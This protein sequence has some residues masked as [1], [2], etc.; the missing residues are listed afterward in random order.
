MSTR[1]DFLDRPPAP[2]RLFFELGIMLDE[3]DF[4]AEQ[5]YH[6]GRLARALAFLHGSGT[7]AGLRVSVPPPE[8]GGPPT[9]ESIE[10]E[11]VHVSPG[12]AVDG[13]GRLIEMPTDRCIRL[14]RWL[15]RE[16]L[17]AEEG[18]SA[19]ARA[20]FERLR[21]AFHPSVPGGTSGDIILD[22]LVRFAAC[23]NG[24]TPA[25]VAGPFDAL[26]AVQP[27][28]IRD[29]FELRL[30]PRTEDPL[31]L[32][33]D[34]WAVLAG[35]PEA[36][37]RSRL[38][39]AVLDAWDVALPAI[40]TRDPMVPDWLDHDGSLHWLFLARLAVPATRATTANA[41][42][43]RVSNEAVEVDNELRPFVYTA[44]ALARLSG[45]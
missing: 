45:L 40:P 16:L 43:V 34:P 31:P 11:E 35:L 12:L 18:A 5:T 19:D 38:Q 24:K 8:G 25:L 29:G 44:N 26:D 6:R 30:V 4:R 15:D 7:A 9:V 2:D 37:R 33:V 36:Q 39:Q 41:P 3:D 13:V 21:Q 17:G 27:S 32:P 42:P 10:T 14:Q 1:P 20:R 28:R 22:L 23:E